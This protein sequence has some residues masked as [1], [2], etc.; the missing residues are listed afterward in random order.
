M[1]CSFSKY[2]LKAVLMT[3]GFV[4]VA[5]KF[6]FSVIQDMAGGILLLMTFGIRDSKHFPTPV[7]MAM[8]FPQMHLN[9][10]LNCGKIS[11]M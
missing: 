9:L 10:D 2:W 6:S 11:I 4:H 3:A 5:L 8:Q 1:G 7:V